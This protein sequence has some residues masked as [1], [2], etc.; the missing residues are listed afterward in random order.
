MI[1]DGIFQLAV[2]RAVVENKDAG[3]YFGSLGALRHWTSEA[4]AAGLID[5]PDPSL[6]LKATRKGRQIYDGLALSTLPKCRAYLWASTEALRLLEA[7]YE[8]LKEKT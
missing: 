6:P 5:S 7:K 8:I 3:T 2:L 1:G 4:H